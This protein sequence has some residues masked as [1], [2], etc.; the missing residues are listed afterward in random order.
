M[1]ATCSKHL[2]SQ[3][4]IQLTS[5]TLSKDPMK[6]QS[7]VLSNFRIANFRM[8]HLTTN[9]FELRNI[10]KYMSFTFLLRVYQIKNSWKQKVGGGPKTKA[11]WRKW[12]KLSVQTD[13]E[14]NTECLFTSFVHP[15]S[16]NGNKLKYCYTISTTFLHILR[17][18]LLFTVPT[19]YNELLL[20]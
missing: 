8:S 4:T 14:D 11:F 1:Y 12:G 20:L 18:K 17:Y 6:F 9:S 15:S 5:Q 3:N 16:C 13:T 7:W 10:K 19:L 2:F